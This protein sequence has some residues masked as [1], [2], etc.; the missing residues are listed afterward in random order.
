VLA[1]KKFVI[2]G[3]VAVV[4]FFKKLFNRSGSSSGGTPAS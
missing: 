2:I 4:A 1:M 3:V